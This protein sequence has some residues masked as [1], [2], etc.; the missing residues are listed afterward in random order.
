MTVSGVIGAINPA[1][2]EELTAAE[3]D[4]R[5][6]EAVALATGILERELA[7]AARLPA[8]AGIVRARSRAPPTPG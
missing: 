6:A 5:F 1:W 2:D 7:G 3:E 4:E 8:R